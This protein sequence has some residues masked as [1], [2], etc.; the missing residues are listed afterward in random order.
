MK[1][2]LAAL[3]AGP[4]APASDIL[5]TRRGVRIRVIPLS[6]FWVEYLRDVVRKEFAERGEPLDPPTYTFATVGGD[7]Q[8]VPH[9]ETT[10]E[11][12]DDPEQTA[13]NRA[14]WAA[15]VDAKARLEQEQS[16]RLERA[17]FLMGAELLDDED[18][19]FEEFCRAIGAPMPE[20]PDE[21]KILYLRGYAM[22]DA[23]VQ[24]FFFLVQV[25]SMAG[26][27]PEEDVQ[28][29]LATFRHQLR[30]QFRLF[31]REL[32]RVTPADGAPAEEPADPQ[33]ALAVLPEVPAGAGG[34][35]LGSD[36]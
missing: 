3:R 20:D 16:A 33:G 21:R 5:T 30:G 32:E 7:S 15:H 2:K 9:D 35:E 13:A 6:D 36:A 19:R 27:V 14:A 26:M 22:N 11:D 34:E 28:A 23:E 1:E 31:L 25:L 4:D 12:P 10:L 29:A 17:Q 24:E 8:T 18:P